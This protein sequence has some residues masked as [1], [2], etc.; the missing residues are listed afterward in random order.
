MMNNRH[1]FYNGLRFFLLAVDDFKL[2]WLFA[3]ARV[4]VFA[5]YMDIDRIGNGF[6]KF[7]RCY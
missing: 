4:N 5:N 2:M 1:F 3:N 6:Y 7:Y